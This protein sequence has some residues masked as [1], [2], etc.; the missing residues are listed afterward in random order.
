MKYIVSGGGGF[1]GGA[2]VRRLVA[3]GHA[4]LSLA[5]GEYSALQAL[6]VHTLQV[7]LGRSSPEELSA[8]ISAQG[9]ADASCFFHVA[10]HVKMWG[11]FEDFYRSNVVGTENVIALCRQLDIPRLV[12]T[13]SPSVIADGSDL[14]GIDETYPYPDKYLAHYPKTKALAEQAVLAANSSSLATCALRP[15]LIFGPGDTNLG[16]TVLEKAKKGQL[17]QVGDGKNL[18]DFC[19]IDDCVTAHVLADSALA[20]RPESR[21][22]AYFITQGDPVPLWEWI[23]ILLEQNGVPPIKRSVSPRVAFAAAGLFELL[24][25]VTGKEPR[26]TRFLIKEMATDHYFSIARARQLLGFEPSTG[27]FEALR[28]EAR[29]ERASEQ[30]FSQNPVHFS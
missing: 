3:E 22:L 20:E 4:V 9:F 26:L 10:S 24:A 12:F 30:Q 14:R 2:L 18:V 8:Q 29:Q 1:V 28:Q 13:S 19:Y 16:P 17:L 21:G 27:V 7:D 6:G 23:A 25:R 15:H 11:A 5:R